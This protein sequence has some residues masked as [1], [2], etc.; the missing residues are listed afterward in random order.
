MIW[1]EKRI[2]L[3]VLGVLLAANL[4]FFLTYRVQYQS[5][6]DDIDTRVES[7]QQQLEQARLAR[8]RTEKQRQSYQQVERDI[9]RVFN[10]LWSTQP[11]RFTIFLGEV[12]RL[13][14]ASNLAPQSYSFS[15]ATSEANKGRQRLEIGAVDVETTFSVTG[16]Y[17]QIRR[18]INL[19][20]LSQ[21]FVII[22]GITLNAPDQDTLTLNLHLK[23]LFREEPQKNAGNRL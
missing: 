14:A 6:L 13:A 4:F 18:L 11:K 23:T 7:L 12:K 22:N 20:E 16:T 15:R 19:L 10:E 9:D 8:I 17:Q 21:Q 2:V 1:R 5:R 3:I